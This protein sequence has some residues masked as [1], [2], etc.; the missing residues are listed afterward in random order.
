MWN[1]VTWWHHW[2]QNFSEK[3]F[4]RFP[5]YLRWF[6]REFTM[7]YWHHTVF[8]QTGNL[9]SDKGKSNYRA[10]NQCP[11]EIRHKAW[12]TN[13]LNSKSNWWL[14]LPLG[15]SLNGWTVTIVKWFCNI[16]V[17]SLQYTHE[18]FLIQGVGNRSNW[19]KYFMIILMGASS[20]SNVYDDMTDLIKSLKSQQYLSFNCNGNMGLLNP[21]MSD[22]ST[23]G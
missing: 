2:K 4:K 1:F 13:L 23:L 16:S 5:L 11:N 15:V 18:S 3:C 20:T 7:L 8:N 9:A 12:S 10:H 14:I 22:D 21:L 19:N 6:Q 17:S